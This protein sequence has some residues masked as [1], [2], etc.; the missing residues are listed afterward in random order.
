ML[1]IH[2]GVNP[3]RFKFKAL[4]DSFA[5]VTEL[6][7]S[8]ERLVKGTFSLKMHGYIIPETIQKDLNSIKK[9]NSKSKII[10]SMETDSNPRKIR[11]K[12]Y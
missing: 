3:D 7:Q 10:F 9:Y 8:Q 5:T 4:I 11:S 1:Q 2:I 6:Q 12:S